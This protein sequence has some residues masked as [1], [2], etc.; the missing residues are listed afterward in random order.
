MPLMS[1]W[2]KKI[3]DKILLKKIEKEGRD[4]QINQ[5]IEECGE[6]AV[7]INHFRRGKIKISQLLEEIADVRIMIRQLSFIYGFNENMVEYMVHLKTNVIAE[8]LKEEKCK[9]AREK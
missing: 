6:L 2:R 3:N 8:S 7:A 5:A 4:E 9:A 1:C